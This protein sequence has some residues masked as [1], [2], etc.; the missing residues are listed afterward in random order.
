M[1]EVTCAIVL[2]KNTFLVLQKQEETEHPLMW[3]FPG[4]KIKSNESS[5]ECIQR[6]IKEELEIE[7]EIFEKLKPV[8]FDYGF[9]KIELIPFLCSPK[10]LQIKLNE[11]KDFEWIQLKD[12]KRVQLLDADKK[13]IQIPENFEI[14]KK[15]L[16]K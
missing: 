12:L 10:S 1:I 3:E 7:I 5:E 9:R 14:L 8:Q 11:H 16:R 2:N 4:G 6:E 15:Y 13:L